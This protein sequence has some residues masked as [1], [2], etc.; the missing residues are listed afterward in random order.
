MKADISIQDKYRPAMT[1]ETQAEA[2]AYFEQLV[3]HSM[4]FSMS[5]GRSREE[6][7][8]IERQSLAYY[9]GYFGAETHAR[10]ERLFQCEHPFFGKIVERGQPT[11]EEAYDRGLLWAAKILTQC[12]DSRM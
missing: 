7:E 5:F 12:R 3:T 11:T 10:V 9:A 8:A 2:D 4:S 1:I 6:A